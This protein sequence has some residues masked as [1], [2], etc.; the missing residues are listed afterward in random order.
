MI[1]PF[2]SE[3]KTPSL[4][5]TAFLSCCFC[6]SLEWLSHCPAC[7]SM[8]STQ[9]PLEE[10]LHSWSLSPQLKQLCSAAFAACCL[11]A[12][13]QSQA[14]L[15]ESGMQSAASSFLNVGF[16]KTQNLTSCITPRP[17]QHLIVCPLDFTRG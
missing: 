5:E 11:S 10:R 12:P 15:T 9:R 8:E 4:E 13:S 3:K 17:S 2:L 7:C 1:I 6:L 16:Q 14:A